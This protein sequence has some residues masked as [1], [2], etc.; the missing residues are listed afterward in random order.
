MKDDEY[1]NN[2]VDEINRLR[3]EILKTEH[4]FLFARM[5]M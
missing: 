3:S 2:L 5:H 1:I 4:V